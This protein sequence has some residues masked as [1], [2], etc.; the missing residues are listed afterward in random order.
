[1]AKPNERVGL[2]SRPGE[3]VTSAS[4][5][6]PFSLS[7]AYASSA[8]EGDD[9]L[10]MGRSLT[11]DMVVVEGKGKRKPNRTGEGELR[12]IEIWAGGHLTFGEPN[13]S[14]KDVR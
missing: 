3:R 8:D 5:T 13:P 7:Y 6:A 2:N 12:C 1:M 4:S 11:V 10:V 9:E 14:W